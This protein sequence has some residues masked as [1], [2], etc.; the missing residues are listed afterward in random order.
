MSDA[1]PVHGTCDPRF[2]KVKEL[3]QHSFDS[4]AEIGAAVCFI[5]D[6]RCAIDLW[7]GYFDLA[8]EREWERDTLAN[9]CGVAKSSSGSRRRQHASVA[10]CRN[11]GGERSW[12]RADVAREA[13]VLLTTALLQW[14]N[15]IP[16]FTKKDLVDRK[17]R[18]KGWR[19]RDVLPFH[20]L[21]YSSRSRALLAL[22]L[23]SRAWVGSL[24]K[25]NSGGSRHEQYS[26]VVVI[27]DGGWPAIESTPDEK[28]ARRGR[29][30]WKA[31]TFTLRNQ[32]GSGCIASCR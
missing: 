6:G 22:L 4:G 28:I 26:I 27:A 9:V 29:H 10:R 17:K 20:S 11:S 24:T 30:A 21:H 7:G 2:T 32:T 5:L 8:H 13:G 25:A 16:I 14:L 3:F 15:S 1:T 19:Y 31:K 23:R 18:Q 12:H